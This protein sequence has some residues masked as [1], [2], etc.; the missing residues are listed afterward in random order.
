MMV[1]IDVYEYDPFKREYLKVSY[2]YINKSYIGSISKFG[3]TELFKVILIDLKGTT[4]ITSLND[5]ELK[6]LIE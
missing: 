1:K 2:A 3:D 6:L 5:N 4:Y